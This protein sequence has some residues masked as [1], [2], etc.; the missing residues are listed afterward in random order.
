MLPPDVPGD[1]P[2]GRKRSNRASGVGRDGGRG[3][4][5][6]VRNVETPG[7]WRQP[8]G[9]WAREK[10]LEPR[11]ERERVAEETPIWS[12]TVQGAIGGLERLPQRYKEVRRL[13][14]GNRIQ[15]VSNVDAHRT[16]GRLIAQSD[17]DRVAV[18][19]DESPEADG[20]V[21]VAAIVKNYRTQVLVDR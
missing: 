18:I 5:M 21:H 12:R 8:G 15:I 11:E 16:Y 17:P 20:V 19:A 13:E 7:P 9:K 6:D 10:K 2:L 4:E 3:G 1:N 14:P